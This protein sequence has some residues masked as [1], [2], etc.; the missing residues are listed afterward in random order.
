MIL[1]IFI[2]V[3]LYCTCIFPWLLHI[4]TCCGHINSNLTARHLKFEFMWPQQV[5]MWGNQGN[6]HVQYSNTV[7]NILRFTETHVLTCYRPTMKQSGS[8]GF[9]CPS[10]RA[11]PR[12]AVADLSVLLQLYFSRWTTST[13]LPRDCSPNQ[14]AVSDTLHLLSDF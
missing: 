7:I 3:L 14:T 1:N 9:R 5:T 6:M 12:T 2:N 11:W 13:R 4:V 8:G 10:A